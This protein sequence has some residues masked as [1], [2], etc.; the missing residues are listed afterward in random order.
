MGDSAGA[1]SAREGRWVE[2][3]GRELLH[4]VRRRYPEL[5]LVAENLGL[6][7]ADVEALRAEFAL[8]GMV[9]LQFAFDGSPDNPY[10][11]H[12]QAR[13]YRVHRHARQQ[14][15]ARLVRKPRRRDPRAGVR[16]LRPSRREHAMDAGPPGHGIARR[17]RHHPLAGFPRARRP[18]P[19]E[20]ARHHRG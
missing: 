7:T 15:H 3:P 17:Y 18:Q 2:A 16:L 12:M 19:H 8:P 20:H 1:I 9:V 5:K 10:L 14:H 13:R 6:I 4:A 11:N